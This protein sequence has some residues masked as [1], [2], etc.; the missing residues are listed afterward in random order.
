[1]ADYVVAPQEL[2]LA[3]VRGDEFGILVDASI[4]LSGYTF[5][6]VIYKVTS[7]VGGVPEG[8]ETLVPFTITNVDLSLGKINL[9]L[10]ESQTLALNP[11]DR[12]RWYLRWVAPGNVTRTVLSGTVTVGDP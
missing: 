10:Q 8:T 6:A 5:T 1:M 7:I 11:R 2:N 4:D 12:M 3:F 9:S